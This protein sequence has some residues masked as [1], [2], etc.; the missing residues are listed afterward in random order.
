L[1]ITVDEGDNSPLPITRARLLL[2]AYRV[3]FFHPGGGLKLLYGRDDIARP[4]YDL[5]LLAPQVMGA[6]ALELELA[7]EDP[8]AGRSAPSL[9]S[10]RVFW[11]GL[12]VAVVA[13]AGLIVKLVR[14]REVSA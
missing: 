14:S 3:R 5:A 4:R 9:V 6:E 10:P 7:A 11:I 13:L 8:F 12:I 1:V 2:P